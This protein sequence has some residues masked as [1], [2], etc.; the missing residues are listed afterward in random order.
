MAVGSGIT[1]AS[2]ALVTPS[3]HGSSL[4]IVT[5]QVSGSGSVTSS[6]AGISCPPNCAFQFPANSTVVLTATPADG[7]VFAGW[8]GA[9]SGS[10]TQCQLS[11][12]GDSSASA[13]FQAAAPPPPPPSPSISLVDVSVTE[14]NS[15][16]TA[17][18]MT[19][20]VFP[21]P[22]E[23]V[24]VAYA[25][26]SGTAGA[27]DYSS[28][29]GTLRIPAGAASATISVPIRGDTVDE[30]D[31][32]VLVDLSSPDRAVIGDGRAVITI[33]DDD[34][35]DADGDGVPVPADCNDSNAAVHPGATE[36]PGNDFDENCDGR[37]APAPDADG[38]GVGSPADCNDA[39]PR[40][41]PGAAEIP[42]NR[43]DENCDGRAAPYP[44]LTVGL[45]ARW[46][47]LPSFTRVLQLDALRV[48]AS[49]RIEILCSSRRLGCA[50]RARTVRVPSARA[51]VQ[52]SSLFDAA[53]LRPGAVIEVRITKPG[54]IG[55]DATYTI[56]RRALPRV[57]S[58]CLRPGSA[59]PMPC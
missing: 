35:P 56:R 24:A 13:T 32:T 45:A 53:E 8:G 23:E 1:L 50:F 25:T 36:I 41:R 31:E 51:R 22:G 48:P 33:V 37:V 15:G 9:C 55:Q 3:G 10:S 54:N 7:W 52:L 29:S 11:G 47:V 17:A 2:I 59:R 43:I 5:V 34:L 19:A 30:P 28:S 14:G 6:P 27:E 40:I 12:S 42:G 26:S 18:T 39:N 44:R 57:R 49:T 38:D 46:R 21:T 16:T 4:G 58:L 20:T